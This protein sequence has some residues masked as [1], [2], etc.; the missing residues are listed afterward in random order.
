MT[1]TL[2]QRQRQ[3]ERAREAFASR[4][5]SPEEKKRY[6]AELG[7]KGAGSR[8]VLTGEEAAA[9]RES[10]ALLSRIAERGKLAPRSEE[11]TG[12]SD[13]FPGRNENAAEG[14]SAASRGR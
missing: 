4:F 13:P 12:A 11:G 5:S 14:E 1:A 3:T 9:L 8:I 6:F 2:S 10:Y 7:R